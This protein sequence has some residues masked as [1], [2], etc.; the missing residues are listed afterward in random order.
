MHLAKSGHE[1]RID[2]DDEMTTHKSNL[3]I[4]KEAIKEYRYSPESILWYNSRKHDMY[5]YHQE[6]A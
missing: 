4:K 6:M 2:S 1:A 5:S 3:S